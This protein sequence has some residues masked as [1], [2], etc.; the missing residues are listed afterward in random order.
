MDDQFVRKDGDLQVNEPDQVVK[1]IIEAANDS[2]DSAGAA[3][4]Y[5]KDF[6]T[7]AGLDMDDPAAI[8][9]VVNDPKELF[10]LISE[11]KKDVE[12]FLMPVDGTK[13]HNTTDKHGNVKPQEKEFIK[14]FVQVTMRAVGTEM[15]MPVEPNKLIHQH[16]W[17]AHALLRG[18]RQCLNLAIRIWIPSHQSPQEM[19]LMI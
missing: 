15:A 10:A 16:Q 13:S 14:R 2:T 3:E 4:G 9:K 6:L 1:A 19:E 7:S 18:R 5:V 11:N 12:D 8:Q 17:Q